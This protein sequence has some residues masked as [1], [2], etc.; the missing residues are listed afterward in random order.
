MLSFLLVCLIFIPKFSQVH[1][2]L[3]SWR[4]QILFFCISFIFILFFCAWIYRKKIDLQLIYNYIVRLYIQ[5]FILISNGNFFLIPQFLITKR[6]LT[7]KG[8][9]YYRHFHNL[10]VLNPEGIEACYHLIS[11]VSF[12]I[13]YLS[14]DWKHQH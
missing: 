5:N 6:G 11:D 13:R 3:G 14:V 1:H 8:W 10:A 12:D 4:L 2:F 9:C 7:R